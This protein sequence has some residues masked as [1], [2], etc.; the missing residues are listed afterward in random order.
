MLPSLSPLIGFQAFLHQQMI[1]NLL[2]VPLCLIALDVATGIL[3]AIKTKTFDWKRLADFLGKDFFHYVIVVLVVGIAFVCVGQRLA[4]DI[5]TGTG[6][7]V[8]SISL[9]A[10]IY[11]NLKE[12]STSAAEVLTEVAPLV[13]LPQLTTA[14]V[15]TPSSPASS[16]A[17]T[18]P[19]APTVAAGTTNTAQIPFPSEPLSAS[20]STLAPTE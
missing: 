4:T 5:A 20:S 13:G 7:T 19:P 12:I 3:S 14:S 10:S 15:P 6:M 16:V 9:F 1:S 17:A 2:F 11:Q 18:P 8:L